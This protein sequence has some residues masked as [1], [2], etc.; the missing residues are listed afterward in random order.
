M[1]F[2]I[3]GLIEIFSFWSRQ[4]LYDSLNNNGS[5]RRFAVNLHFLDKIGLIGEFYKLYIRI[6]LRSNIFRWNIIFFPIL[7][8]IGLF[9]LAHGGNIMDIPFV[10]RTFYIQLMIGL[11]G[12]QFSMMFSLESS[13]FDVLISSQKEAPFKILKY[14][15]YF[16]VSITFFI[17]S[18]LILFLG[19]LPFIFLISS[20]FYVIGPIFFILFQNAVYNK[21][22]VDLFANIFNMNRSNSLASSIVM[23]AC[24]SFVIITCVIALY[25][26]EDMACYFMLTIGI[27]V[28]ALHPIWLRNIHNRFMKQ[29]YKN[30]DNF[31]NF[32]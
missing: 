15:Y 13:F 26:S 10:I 29:R 24:F 8:V 3:V 7:F 21:I 9:S 28:F 22:R 23:I 20:F 25:T 5:K 11:I 1:L 4:E 12:F 17:A 6:I 19:D 2:S 14:K 31:R 32:N 27:I 18:I 16:C 30:M